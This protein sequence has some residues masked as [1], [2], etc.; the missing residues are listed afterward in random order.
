V[1]GLK[2]RWMGEGGGG[3]ALFAS[4]LEDNSINYVVGRFFYRNFTWEA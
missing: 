3:I 4:L 1:T 2:D